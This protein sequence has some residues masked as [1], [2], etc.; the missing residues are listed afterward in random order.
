MKIGFVVNCVA[1]EKAEDTTSVSPS[2]PLVAG[3]R[4]D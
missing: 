1:T 2:R 4:R 3:M